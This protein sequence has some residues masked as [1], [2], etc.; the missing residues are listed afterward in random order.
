MRHT[1]A[2]PHPGRPHPPE[3]HNAARPVPVLLRTKWGLPLLTVGSSVGGAVVVALLIVLGGA[4]HRYGAQLGT[5]LQILAVYVVVA[6]LAAVRG[7]LALRR[8][9][10]GWLDTSSAPTPDHARHTLRLPTE[11]TVLIGSLW[12]GGILAMSG[13]AFALLPV[14]EALGG[15][16]LMTLGGLATVG[17]N[18]LFVERA[19]RPVMATI[20]AVDTPH[21]PPR[22]SVISRLI[23]TW[24]LTSALPLAAA[25]ALLHYPDAAPPDRI[26]AATYLAALGLVSGALAETLLARAVAQPIHQMRGALR[27][28]GQGRLD[29]RVPVD[30]SSEIGVLQSTVN[31]MVRGLQEQDRLRDL[32]GRHVGRDVAQRALD[33]GADLTGEI[34][35]ITAL[36]VDVTNSTA[37]AH[38]ISPQEFVD[39][40][41]RLLAEVI[42]ATESHHGLVNKFEGDAA[43][44]I[45]GAPVA[46]AD[47]ADSALHAARQI[48][49]RVLAHGELDIGI[50]LATG[51]V[52]A[53]NLGTD[54]RLE[55]TVIGDAVNEASRLTELAK[56]T[57]GRILASDAVIRAASEPEREYW[58]PHGD[59]SLRGR[60]LPTQTWESIPPGN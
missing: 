44:C 12:A 55:Y 57:P 52:F 7:V 39:K 45:F 51:P 31:D 20:L 4:P 14:W 35:E 50:G 26:H 40:L 24:A 60:T 47:A 25:I 37:L 17:Y 9:S 13:S 6:L 33:R 3:A 59:C 41:N 27:R 42:A 16:L 21:A 34:R 30:D 28:I 18:Y 10:L 2:R 22:T 46:R 23:L 54:Q 11:S 38:Q 56:H 48:R 29:V 53:G 32:F 15:T 5:L 19:L 43:L 36:F 58:T 1:S 49:D 8:R